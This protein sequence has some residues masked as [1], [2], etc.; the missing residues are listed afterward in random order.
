MASTHSSTLRKILSLGHK[1]IT[2]TTMY[3]MYQ[4][5]ICHFRDHPKG[6][7]FLSNCIYRKGRS[8][9]HYIPSLRMKA[10][11]QKES[12]WIQIPAWFKEVIWK[13]FKNWALKSNFCVTFDKW[14]NLS[15]PQF[16]LYK[17]RMI[18]VFISQGYVRI[19][20]FIWISKFM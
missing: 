8:W 6:K 10:L 17:L 18:T 3:R 20:K 4:A 16:F 5:V 7:I 15:V 2:A 9:F 11:E 13:A 1:I 12:V 14:L 19:S